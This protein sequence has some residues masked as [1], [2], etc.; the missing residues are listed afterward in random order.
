MRQAPSGAARTGTSSVGRL[1]A[2]GRVEPRGGPATPRLRT[3]WPAA[4]R[5]STGAHA[6]PAPVVGARRRHQARTSARYI[7]S[8]RHATA[9][10]MDQ[11]PARAAFHQGR[12]SAR[13]MVPR[14]PRRQAARKGSAVRRDPEADSDP[15]SL[16]LGRAQS[17]VSSGSTIS[18]PGNVPGSICTCA[19]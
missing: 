19:S 5:A 8:R 11:C 16:K 6:A 17:L 13:R 12:T 1:T 18:L 3:Q 10:T 4:H 7:G 14:R 2:N 9:P 15:E